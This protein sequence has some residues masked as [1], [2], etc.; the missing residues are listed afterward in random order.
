M[1]S[2][3]SGLTPAT[4]F[5]NQRRSTAI[6]ARGLVCHTNHSANA[7]S[8]A[9]RWITTTRPE[10]GQR[11]SG[12]TTTRPEQG[13]RS[14]GIT[15]TQ[16]QSNAQ[17]DNSKGSAPSGS[18]QPSK[19]SNAIKA[20]ACGIERGYGFEKGISRFST[21]RHSL[22]LRASLQLHHETTTVVT[23]SCHVAIFVRCCDGND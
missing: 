8:S 20:K 4:P 5:E 17:L 19:R 15:A 2:P 9:R 16:Q 18:Q 3:V 21:I 1:H 7:R 6:S 13:Q 14:S 10:Q 23:H 11:S 22:T 12:I